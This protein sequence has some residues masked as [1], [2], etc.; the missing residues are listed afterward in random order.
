MRE[1]P[2]LSRW[3]KTQST[4]RV[5]AWRSRLSDDVI[6]WYFFLHTHMWKTS[7]IYKSKI[8]ENVKKYISETFFLILRFFLIRQKNIFHVLLHL[9]VL[10]VFDSFSFSYDS[11]CRAKCVIHRN[12]G[13][14]FHGKLTWASGELRIESL[15]KICCEIENWEVFNVSCLTHSNE[16]EKGLSSH[17]LCSLQSVSF[18]REFEKSL[19]NKSSEWIK[20]FW[21]SEEWFSCSKESWPRKT[22]KTLRERR[23]D[24][25]LKKRNFIT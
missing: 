4:E 5:F 15:Y 7:F 17:F 10:C 25:N 6:V 20:Y 9:L 14:T 2:T 8:I 16:L 19:K 1:K 3:H 24:T 13:D 11:S 18:T 12:A 22:Q 21:K 23:K